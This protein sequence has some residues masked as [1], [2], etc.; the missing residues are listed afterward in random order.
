[1]SE[2][3][4]GSSGVRCDAYHDRILQTMEEESGDFGLCKGVILKLW[5]LPLNGETVPCAN[6]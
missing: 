3:E 4:E 5:V 6:N 2:Y 1:M